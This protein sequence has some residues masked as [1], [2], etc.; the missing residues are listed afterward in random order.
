MP[1]TKAIDDM[2][3]WSVK[4]INHYGSSETSVFV[5]RYEVLAYNHDIGGSGCGIEEEFYRK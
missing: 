1:W 2:S 4:V 5:D 3:E